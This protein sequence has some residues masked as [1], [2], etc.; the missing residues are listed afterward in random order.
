MDIVY[1]YK[2]PT[3]P[4]PY[5]DT[6]QKQWIE[7][8]AA[9]AKK[10]GYNTV[11]YTDDK[12]LKVIS[13]VD[14]IHHIKCNS[15]LWDSL[16]IKVLQLRNDKNYFLSDYDIIYREQIKFDDFSDVFFD[17]YETNIETWNLV[18]KEPSQKIE[19]L[20]IP[21]WKSNPRPVM[22]LGILKFNNDNLKIKYIE[23]WYRLEK[24]TTILD[25]N[26][27]FLTATISQ[28][29][30]TLLTAEYKAKHFTTEYLGA[31][32]KYYQ[33]F[34]GARKVIKFGPTVVI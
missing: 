22:N 4:I 9:S 31:P 11:L 5:R 16:K 7:I 34:V 27:N 28:L 1:T 8:S 14:Q 6:L 26:S 25:I 10:V 3:Y 19:I 24:E 2:I 21:G 15:R 20:N 33:H 32:N 13:N 29:L 18:Y 23:E 17:T 12:S 30:L